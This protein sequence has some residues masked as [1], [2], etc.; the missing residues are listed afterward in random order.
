[1]EPKELEKALLQKLSK[2]NMDKVFVKDTTTAILNLAKQ[3]YVFDRIRWK[4]TPVP[5]TIYV[6]GRP[7]D[8]FRLKDFEGVRVQM[9]IF[10]IGIIDDFRHGVEL[11]FMESHR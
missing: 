10:P 1:M 3:G 5:D 9:D 7:G 6:S 2:S 8:I 11:N 4:G